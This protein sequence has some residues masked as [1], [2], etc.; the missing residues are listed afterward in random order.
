M[1]NTPNRIISYK[2]LN[3]QGQ[4]NEKNEKNIKFGTIALLGIVAVTTVFG[5]KMLERP[6]EYAGAKT[7][8]FKEYQGLNDATMAVNR[9]PEQVPYQEVTEHIKNMPENEQVLSDGIRPGETITIPESAFK[10]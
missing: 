7:Y 10:K 9:D 4:R 8:T 5:A 2:E 6:T 1:N 3:N